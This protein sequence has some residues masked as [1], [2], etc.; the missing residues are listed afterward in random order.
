MH[1]TTA[2]TFGLTAITLALPHDQT[3]SANTSNTL[4]KRSSHPWIASF[5]LPGCATHGALPFPT[6]DHKGKHEET[7]YI[8]GPRPKLRNGKCVRWH[9]EVNS[10][11]LFRAK[12]AG[13]NWGSGPLEATRIAFHTTDNCNDKLSHVLHRNASHSGGCYD[14]VNFSGWQSVS[15]SVGEPWNGDAGWDPQDGAIWL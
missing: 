9:R 3:N 6:T 8:D 4:E 10:N 7:D 5:Y 13:V 14:I 12:Y 2:L 11:P 1:L 15:A